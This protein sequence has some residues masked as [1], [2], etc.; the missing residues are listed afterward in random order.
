MF[1]IS[2]HK[3][4]SAQRNKQQFFEKNSGSMNP[5]QFLKAKGEKNGY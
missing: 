3:T 1:T 2:A 4:I 5:H